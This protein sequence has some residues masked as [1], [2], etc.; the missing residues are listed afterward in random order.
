MDDQPNIA[1][2]DPIYIIAGFLSPYTFRRMKKPSKLY[3][4]SLKSL[5]KKE[6]EFILERE[7]KDE[8]PAITLKGASNQCTSQNFSAPVETSQSS[9]LN[10]MSSSRKRG[11]YRAFMDRQ[12]QRQL[13]P[14]VT[15]KKSKV[16]EE[17]IMQEIDCYFEAAC[18]SDE[19]LLAFWRG[20]CHRFPKLAKLARQVAS[21]SVTSANQERIFSISGFIFGPRRTRMK[22]NTLSKAVML[23]INQTVTEE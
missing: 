20:N 9:S 5:M 11:D 16:E 15:P 10:L 18:A 12:L 21:V 22:P 13:Q 4:K 17:D 1:F 7:K 19:N 2:S 14:I 6:V 23:K 3:E 8:T